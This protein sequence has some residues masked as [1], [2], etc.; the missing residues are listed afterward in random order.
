MAL[1]PLRTTRWVWHFLR[2]QK[3][4]KLMKNYPKLHFYLLTSCFFT[5]WLLKSLSKTSILVSVQPP[6]SQT[7]HLWPHLTWQMPLISGIYPDI[8]HLCNPFVYTTVTFWYILAYVFFLGFL[9]T[10]NFFSPTLMVLTL[11]L[12]IF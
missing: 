12:F 7:M 6:N 5:S 2:A 11:W 8:I 1:P 4:V 3:F 9:L 10:T